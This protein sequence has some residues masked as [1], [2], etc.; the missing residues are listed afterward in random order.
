MRHT[1]S[2]DRDLNNP[3]YYNF[4]CFAS[5]VSHDAPNSC[6]ICESVKP[7]CRTRCLTEATPVGSRI[8]ILTQLN[9]CAFALS[10]RSSR[11]KIKLGQLSSNGLAFCLHEP[12]S[13]IYPAQPHARIPGRVENL[14]FRSCHISD[15]ELRQSVT[16]PV[17]IYGLDLR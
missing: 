1:S 14:S 13:A 15:R 17:L 6:G 7:Q 12:V 2:C 11:D 10:V 5:C 16:A 8:G 9:S 4:P 3:L